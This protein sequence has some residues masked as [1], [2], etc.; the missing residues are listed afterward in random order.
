M[1]RVLALI[2]TALMLFSLS[3]CGNPFSHPEPTPSPTPEPTPTPTATPVP[4]PAPTPVPV[5]DIDKYDY[6][7]QTNKTLGVAFTYPAHW[8]NDPGQ[9]TISYVEPVEEGDIPARFAI[10]VKKPKKAPD[11]DALKE[12]IQKLGDSI[13]ADYLNFETVST[14]KNG[15]LGSASALSL[16]YTAEQDGT[17]IK[18]Q[19]LLTYVKSKKRIYALH[20]HCS[21]A[22]YEAFQPV[23]KKIATSFRSA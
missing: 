4:T 8:I 17:P 1:K 12:E 9:S 19:I 13:A 6:A 7:K 16:V 3:G 11:K 20:F 15:K 5:V 2:L 22:D 18:G 21:E 23:L 14:S 10:S